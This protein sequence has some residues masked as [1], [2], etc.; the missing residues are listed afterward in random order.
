MNGG[1]FLILT[2]F[3]KLVSL[4]SGTGEQVPPAN[5]KFAETGSSF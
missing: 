4:I 3:S 5:F 2:S 1:N